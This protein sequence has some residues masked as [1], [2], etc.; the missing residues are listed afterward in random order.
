[1]TSLALQL[2]C[3]NGARYLPFLFASLEAQTKKDWTLYV[4]DNG[5]SKEEAD[6]IAAVVKN[7]SFPII[8]ERV[9]E[10]LNFARGHN[11]LFQKH[12]AELVQLLNDDAILEPTYLEEVYQTMIAHPSCGS[13]SG[14]VFQ[15]DF[16]LANTPSQ[17]KTDRIDTL[18]LEVLKTG[19]VR[20][21]FFGVPLARIS[22]KQLRETR[23]FGVSGCL[24]MVRRSL[25]RKATGGDLLF[26]P[27]FVSYKEDV[28]LAYQLAH[29]GATSLIAHSAVAYHKRSFAKRNHAKQPYEQQMRS[30]RNHLWILM[31]MWSV[32]DFFVRAWAWI[33][34][35][36]AKAVYFA[37]NRPQVL[38]DAWG[39]TV[40]EWG[41]LLS[42]RRQHM[43][44][45]VS[46]RGHFVPLVH[47]SAP[48]TFA[49]V[50]VSHNELNDEY[51]SSLVRA[52]RNTKE[53]VQVIIVD[54]ASTKY[55][56][57][58]YAD[59]FFSA[60]YTVILR[61]GDFGFGRSCNRGVLEARA[62]YV[63]FLN[64]DTVIPDESFFDR[65]KAFFDANPQAGVV[66]PR[67][68]YF[69]GSLQETCRRFP[70]WYMPLVQRTPLGNT[71]FGKRYTNQFLLRDFSHASVR[72][73]D[74]A[75]GSALCVP[76]PLLEELG[77]FDDRF[78][79][80][81][82]DIDLC[83]RV[84]QTGHPVYYVPD[85]L[86]KHAYGKASA[87]AKNFVWNALTNTMARA[88]I[89]SWVKYV[90]KWRRAKKI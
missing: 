65:L 80:Y 62:Q 46:S 25:V 15:W 2:T 77:G 43:Q 90:W 12:T 26:D 70:A 6:A 41:N 19:M 85:I 63:L 66:A 68:Q 10:T 84:W 87:N 11:H 76:K 14:R 73:V 45:R 61:N 48:Y 42:K 13:A 34:F 28:L 39:Q 59:R 1:M 78:W 71:A 56:A 16:D 64:P 57:N 89:A 44:S 18:G 4:L 31:T 35:E 79:M 75:Q 54:N 86:V 17:G 30:Y 74:W 49:V 21:R 67:V 24:P 47:P 38:L 60:D 55:H 52:I 69:D 7:A 32:R 81:F 20:E 5:S 72:M 29:S 40:H 37:I 33:P 36:C 83:R 27:S 58:E 50:T 23:V 53:R 3:Y 22:E 88:H 8:F 82:E 9:Q 51:F